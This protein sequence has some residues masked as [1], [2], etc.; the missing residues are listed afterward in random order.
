MKYTLFIFLLLAV[1][2]S[3]VSAQQARKVDEALLLEHYQ[4]QRFADAFSYLKQVYPEPVTDKKELSNLAYTASMAGR[5]PEAEA[6]YQRLLISD[7]TNKAV[8]FNLAGINKRRGN[9]TKA[10]LYYRKIA[11]VDTTNF[12][13]YDQLAQIC[14]SK[15]DVMGQVNFLQKANKINPT[16]GDVAA[17]LS[18]LYIGLKQYTVAEKTLKRALEADAENVVLQQGL[19]KLSYALS[20]WPETIATGEQLLILGDSSAATIIKLGRAYYQTKS[21]QCSINILNSLPQNAQNETSAY[22]TG[23]C[24]KQLKDQANAIA[25][26]N[27]AIKL[28]VSTSTS[29]YYNEMADSYEELKQ[30]QKA[31]KQYEKGFLYDENILAYY[32]LGNL[33]DAKLK[34]RKNALK[35]FK[36][37]LAGKPGEKQQDYIDYSKSRVKALGGK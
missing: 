12:M 31:R 25:A 27:K 32:Y 21:Y 9:N 36:K 13:V 28:S 4:N 22:L 14:Q 8:L 23:I 30:Y 24:Y 16:N 7:T 6:F 19:L 3:T 37:Y 33:Y 1:S 34:D 17:D 10:E 2:L 29:S 5:L 26:F 20:K 18:A 35:Y 11:A 15:G